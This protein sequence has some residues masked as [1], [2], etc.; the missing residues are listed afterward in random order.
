MPG[1]G[2][3]DDQ[4]SLGSEVF[5]PAAIA[6][7][8]MRAAAVRLGGGALRARPGASRARVRPSKRAY[9]RGS[10]DRR[11]PVIAMTRTPAFTPSPRRRPRTRKRSRRGSPDSSLATSS[12]GRRVRPSS[13]AK[14]PGPAPRPCPFQSCRRLPP[15]RAHGLPARGPSSSRR[16]PPGP[17]P[18]LSGPSSRR[19]LLPGPGFRFRLWPPPGPR[20]CPVIA[21]GAG[22]T[23]C[24]GLPP[25]ASSDGGPRRS[26]SQEVH[27]MLTRGG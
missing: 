23:A 9:A 17:G 15:G 24:P 25:A 5:R 6:A 21:A 13:M 4:K 12:S 1:L 11:S 16:R 27:R 26:R 20:P 2:V 8:L 14:R 3:R 22:P 18:R 10:G 19:R 7:A